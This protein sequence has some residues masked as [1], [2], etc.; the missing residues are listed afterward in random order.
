MTDPRRA[1]LE[2][3]LVERAVAGLDDEARR[4]LEGLLSEHPDVSKH[5]GARRRIN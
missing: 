2:E 1:R 3:L 4:E 5:S